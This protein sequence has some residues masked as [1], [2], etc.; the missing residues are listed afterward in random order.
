VLRSWRE[1]VRALLTPRKVILSR[2]IWPNKSQP[3]PAEIIDVGE[4]P[5]DTPWRAALD[6]FAQSLAK[7][8][9]LRRPVHLALSHHYVR[10]A[11]VPWQAKIL[12]ASSRAIQAEHRFKQLYGTASAGWRITVSESAFGTSALAAAI[13]ENLLTEL[14]QIATKNKSSFDV[15]EPWGIAPI[16]A[17]RKR[18]RKDHNNALVLAEE[19]KQVVL[20]FRGIALAGIA[21]RRG[22]ESSENL[23]LVVNQEAMAVGLAD[24]EQ[25]M[26]VAHC[27]QSISAAP[28][29]LPLVG[30]HPVAPAL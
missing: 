10:F 6:A 3:L 26:F 13:E 7:A 21:T 22:E 27:E 9:T 23:C 2:S 29:I 28:D 20:L 16:N 30:E 18:L 25:R 24:I 14:H 8:G 17:F 1:T 15:I 11:D 19:G 5:A 4:S 12:T